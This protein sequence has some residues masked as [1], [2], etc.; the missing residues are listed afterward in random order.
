M[1]LQQAKE[2]TTIILT[3][4][5]GYYKV[6]YSSILIILQYPGSWTELYRVKN[7]QEVGQVFRDLLYREEVHGA[8]IDTHPHDLQKNSRGCVF[9]CS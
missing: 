3:R 5:V 7:I 1:F 4:G 6:A 8:S 9:T 2:Y